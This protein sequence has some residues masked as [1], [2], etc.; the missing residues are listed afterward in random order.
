MTTKPPLTHP[1][2]VG[3]QN[4]RP[5]Q[6][7]RQP[8]PHPIQSDLLP[9]APQAAKQNNHRVPDHFLLGRVR[10]VGCPHVL[11][12]IAWGAVVRG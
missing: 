10:A 3:Q 8:S 6:D 11:G 4:E 9:G 2:A 5:L 7:H 1:Y 12:F